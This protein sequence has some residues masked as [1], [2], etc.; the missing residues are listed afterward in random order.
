MRLMRCA[1]SSLA[2]TG[3]AISQGHCAVDS[4]RMLAAVDTLTGI[5][6]SIGERASGMDNSV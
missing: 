6:E 3:W 4:E 1:P 2:L 5:G